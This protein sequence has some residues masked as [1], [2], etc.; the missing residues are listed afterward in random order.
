MKM[1]MRLAVDQKNTLDYCIKKMKHKLDDL[2]DII[3][4]T[5]LHLEPDYREYA[6]VIEATSPSKAPEL[7]EKPANA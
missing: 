3:D 7:C 2:P 6:P 4:V 5:P 1:F